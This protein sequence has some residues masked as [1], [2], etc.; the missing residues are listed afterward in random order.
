MIFWTYFPY[1]FFASDDVRHSI[2]LHSI[3]DE[4]CVCGEDRLGAIFV[5]RVGCSLLLVICTVSFHENR[6]SKGVIFFDVMKL[7]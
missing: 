3:F 6:C 4:L 2:R 1:F 5:V 7:Q